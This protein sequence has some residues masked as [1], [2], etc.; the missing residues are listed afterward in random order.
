MEALAHL[1]A[2]A[3]APGENGYYKFYNNTKT[4]ELYTE[5]DT[6]LATDPGSYYSSMNAIKTSDGWKVYFG[7]TGNNP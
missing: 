1:H 2:T 4:Y 6:D 5:C 3:P 7:L